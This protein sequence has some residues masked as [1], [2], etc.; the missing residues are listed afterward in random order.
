MTGLQFFPAFSRRITPVQTFVVGAMVVAMI[1]WN[2][3]FFVLR[4]ANGPD[5][6][7]Y[8][9]WGT[10]G[11]YSIVKNAVGG[12]EIGVL[13]A[14]TAPGSL[15]G[16]QTNVCIRDGVHGLAVTEIVKL[17]PGDE[18]IV[19]RVETA[20]PPGRCGTRTIAR[21]VPLD[22]PPGYYEIRR[23]MVL[24]VRGRP[25]PVVELPYLHIRVET[26]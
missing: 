16:W 4:Q 8:E 19:T 10:T 25:R 14:S 21:L 2:V 6:P 3:S 17:S 9:Y 1:V 13:I 24:T 23:Q 22:A 11:P 7:L 15:I 5:G 20:I 18:E 26:P 12:A